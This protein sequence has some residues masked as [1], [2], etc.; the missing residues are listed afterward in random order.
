[1]RRGWSF[2]IVVAAVMLGGYAD[3]ESPAPATDLAIRR[4]EAFIAEQRM[5]DSQA[6]TALGHALQSIEHKTCMRD[7]VARRRAQIEG[8]T[9]DT[10]IEIGR[11]EDI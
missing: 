5:A 3:A 10:L 7:L 1:M 9:S 6:C 2:F 8:A 4:I 11:S